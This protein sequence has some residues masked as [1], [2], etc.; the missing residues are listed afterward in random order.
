LGST[1]VESPRRLRH[2]TETNFEPGYAKAQRER[3]IGWLA[4]KTSDAT[5]NK[6][7]PAPVP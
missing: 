7:Y 2:G 1:L 6:F 3:W 4:V 5:R